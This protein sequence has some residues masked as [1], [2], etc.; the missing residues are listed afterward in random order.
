VG[1]EQPAI[2]KARRKTVAEAR[3]KSLGCPGCRVTVRLV[4]HGPAY[5]SCLVHRH[6]VRW[7]GAGAG[8]GGPR[9]TIGPFV[10]DDEQD[11]SRTVRLAFP[12]QF[13]QF[14]TWWLAWPA[15]VPEG[16]LQGVF[17]LA[18]QDPFCDERGGPAGRACPGQSYSAVVLQE[19]FSNATEHRILL[20][21]ADGSTVNRNHPG[22]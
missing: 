10:E 1:G 4:K 11:G 19:L 5:A 17:A 15:H 16:Y 2:G 6:V 12:E 13:P 9:L 3:E 18:E 20:F 21:A 22:E 7:P 14:P 8:Y